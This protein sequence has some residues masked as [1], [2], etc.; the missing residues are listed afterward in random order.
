MTTQSRAEMPQLP[1]GDGTGLFYWAVVK[2][3]LGSHVSAGA[4]RASTMLRQLAVNI[5]Q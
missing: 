3:H 1:P 5:V 4:L 2:C